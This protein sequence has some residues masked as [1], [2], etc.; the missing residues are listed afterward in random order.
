MYSRWQSGETGYPYRICNSLKGGGEA[1]R[2]HHCSTCLIGNLC[3]IGNFCLAALTEL[4]NLTLVV[5]L[6]QG[7][8]YTALD[9]LIWYKWE[10]FWNYLKECRIP[11]VVCCTVNASFDALRALITP[12][13]SLVMFGG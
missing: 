3:L 12:D 4:T 1:G 5:R 9:R 2:A 7:L 13:E 6:T 8:P 10:L 11:D